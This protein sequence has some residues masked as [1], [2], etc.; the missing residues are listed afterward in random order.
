MDSKGL[1]DSSESKTACYALRRLRMG[2][3][4]RLHG[5]NLPYMILDQQV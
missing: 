1:S 4:E 5:G 3:G 2:A